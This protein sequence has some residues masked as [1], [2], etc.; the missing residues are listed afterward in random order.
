M[1]F[2]AEYTA[3]G[4]Q[5][6]QHQ[7]YWHLLDAPAYAPDAEQ[8]APWRDLGRADLTSEVLTRR[9]ERYLRLLFDRYG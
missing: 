4:G 6:S 3:A 1:N 2:A 7:L 8:A 5:L 9:L